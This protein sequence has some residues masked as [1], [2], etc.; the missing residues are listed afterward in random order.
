MFSMESTLEFLDDSLDEDD[1]FDIL[2]PLLKQFKLTDDEVIEF[3]QDF[4]S[5][6]E[7]ESVTCTFE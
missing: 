5:V 2:K 7:K 4:M 3:V 6:L 1:W